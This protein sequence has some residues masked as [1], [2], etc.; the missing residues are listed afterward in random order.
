METYILT[1]KFRKGFSVSGNPPVYFTREIGELVEGTLINDPNNTR[2]PIVL[3]VPFI[4]YGQ[5]RYVDIPMNMLRKY[6]NINQIYE[7]KSSFDS[8][9]I[10]L[11][12]T[13]QHTG[14]KV[15]GY[16]FPDNLDD[17]KFPF[18]M[19][20]HPNYAVGLKQTTTLDGVTTT[21]N[22][23][24]P[25]KEVIFIKRNGNKLLTKEGYFRDVSKGVFD[26]NRVVISPEKINTDKIP[27][28]PKSVSKQPTSNSTLEE[29]LN[30]SPL[31]K[32]ARKI[33]IG[34]SVVGWG[35][36]GILAYKF[37]NKSMTWK[38]LLSVFGAY[39]LYST[40]KIFSKPALKVSGGSNSTTGTGKTTGTTTGTTSN[41]NLTKAEKIN[42]IVSNMSDPEQ[43]ELDVFNKNFMSNLSDSELNT[44]IKISKALKDTDLKNAGESGNKEQVYKLLMSK[45]QLSQ[46]EFESAM[47]KYGEALM[48]GVM[49]GVGQAFEQGLQEGFTNQNQSAFSNFESSLN[50]DL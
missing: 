37:W 5:N 30:N 7:K 42:S 50:L 26:K 22:I 45:Y 4:V 41:T 46:Q 1:K 32:T 19:L 29:D 44:W 27:N 39:N 23:D 2:F 48:S 35:V 36:F 38:V 43:K 34:F 49:S 31:G 28:I 20:F 16:K 3:R 15:T 18:K 14:K 8:M 13:A 33:Q 11:E 12:G 6:R 10:T 21:K 17:L 9:L 24:V 25:S 40:Y 47:Q